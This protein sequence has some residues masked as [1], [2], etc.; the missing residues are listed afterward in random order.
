MATRTTL[1]ATAVT[2]MSALA[3]A[4][5]TTTAQADDDRVEVY[6]MVDVGLETYSADDEA[7]GFIFPGFNSA[8][9]NN[10]AKD[11]ALAN[12]VSSRIGVRGGED[13]T[14]NLRASYN[15]ELGIDIL[16]ETGGATGAGSTGTRLGWAGL[17]GDWGEV[18]VGTDWM[19]L[20]E[21]GGW[22]T[23]RTDMHGYGSYYYTTG[24]LRDSAQFGFRQGS[25]VSYQYGSAWGH[26]D[27]FAF[28]ITAGIGEGEDNEEGISS[29]QAAAQYSFN[30]A[31]S[32]NAV[33]YQEFVDGPADDDEAT[34]YNV[35]AR[36]NVTPALELAAN[37]TVVTDF[38]DAVA[39]S[40]TDGSDERDSIALAAMYDFGQ[41]WDGHLGV[42][43]A[44]ADDI[45]DIDYNVYGF[46]RHSFTNRTNARLEFEHIDY[47]GDANDATETVGMVALQHNF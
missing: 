38:S 2:S 28:N 45:A 24:V 21:F 1:K 5:L 44:S 30:D 19:A 36:W 16:N 33:V 42:S 35:G 22:N 41:G 26:S 32:V 46:V 8:G 27:P 15:I 14:P 23:H 25:T 4:A 6:G 12:G 20:Y 39:D 29:L 40:G 18:R 11:F 3:L 10:D 9:G 13:L 34:L 43:Q 7:A 17:G 31:I 47:D 37:Y